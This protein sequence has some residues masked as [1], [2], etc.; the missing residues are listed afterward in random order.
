VILAHDVRPHDKQVRFTNS[1]PT[2]PKTKTNWPLLSLLRFLLATI[3]LFHH[4]SYLIDSTSLATRIAMYCDANSAVFAFLLISGFS[5]AHSITKQQSGF[6][7]RRFERL[8]P[9][10]YL[11]LLLAAGVYALYILN[12]VPE[13]LE[14]PEMVESKRTWLSALFMMGG[15]CT[16]SLPLM[17]PAW[18]LGLEVCYYLVAPALRRASPQV[19][20]G[21]AVA[22]GC[23]YI[24]RGFIGGMTYSLAPGPVTVFC[25]FWPW[26]VG[27]LLYRYQQH[28]WRW[29]MLVIALGIY[30]SGANISLAVVGLALLEGHRLKFSARWNKIFIYA[31]DVSFPLYL[32][33]YPAAYLGK[34]LIYRGW[35]PN[36][37]AML[38]ALSYGLAI[39]ITHIMAL[40]TWLL[41]KRSR[42]TVRA[43][44]L[45]AQA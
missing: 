33:H 13:D 16:L 32:S 38:M 25:L 11:C 35:Y 40:R 7:R 37:D 22:S 27:W 31:G 24:L 29:P 26:L 44:L 9:T 5:I 1:D 2:K 19:L 36:S 20:V 39:V 10:Y 6:Y 43:E 4:S 15:V 18:S 12:T 41:R 17:Q 34:Y 14:W 8:A 45:E 28:P 21:L 42:A 30:S 3:V 23:A